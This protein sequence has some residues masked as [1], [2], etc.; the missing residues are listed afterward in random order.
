MKKQESESFKEYKTRVM[1][2]KSATFCGAKWYNATIWLGHGQTTS[3]HLPA[4]HDIPLEE[5]KDNPSAIH[6]TPHKKKMRK[7]ML[8]GDRPPECY[9]CWQVEDGGE[10]KISDRVFKT[11]QYDESDLNLPFSKREKNTRSVWKLFDWYK[12]KLRKRNDDTFLRTLEVSF[13]R[14]CNFACSYCNPPFSTTWVKDIKDNGPYENIQSDKREHYIS[15]ADWAANVAKTDEDNP[16]IQAFWEWWEEEGGLVDTLE[17]IRI[18]GGEPIMHPSV[19]K[20]FDWFK[21]NPERGKN[22]RFAINSN[23]VPEKEKTFQKLL[24]VVQYAPNFEMFSSCEATG[25]QAEYIRDGMDYEVWIN[26]VKRLL[27]QPKVKKTCIMMTINAL[28][29]GSITD[30][31]DDMLALREIYGK[32]RSPLLSLNPVYNPEFQSISTLPTYIIEHYNDKLKA[33]HDK[34]KEELGD[35]ENVWVTRII[36][37]M[38]RAINNPHPEE[39]LKKRQ[40]DFKSFYTQYDER[41]GKDFRATFDPIMVDWYDSLTVEK[42]TN[43]DEEFEKTEI[44]LEPIIT[45]EEDKHWKEYFD[46]L[47]NN[48]IFDCIKKKNVLEIGT[49]DGM[50]WKHYNKYNPSSITG[51][52]PDDRWLL[53]EGVKESD[54]IRESYETYLPKTE[55]DVIIC[56][57]LICKLHSPIH[58]LELIA[59]SRPEY[60]ILEDIDFSTEQISLTK[61]GPNTN[62]IGEL[63]V[64]DE[65]SCPH[66]TRLSTNIIISIMETMSYKLENNIELKIKHPSKYETSQFVFKREKHE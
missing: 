12:N 59:R 32:E 54:I 1:D 47:E 11:I 40:S 52:D 36:D 5:L 48:N 45:D 8:E 7:M 29:L 65:I 38:N 3:C 49:A 39:L 14:A 53:K 44:K 15:T 51:L 23:L 25:A 9:K 60:I 28:C 46:Q 31:L 34:R 27:D 22:M 50:F 17:E 43:R 10:D 19:W 64:I 35:S 18:T 37:H 41:R 21:N 66:I 63:I 16:Y 2:S 42:N 30:F 33:W 57:G 4:S 13:D 58:L 26:N 56:F 61:M 20:L 62:K 24:D 6:N 55:Y